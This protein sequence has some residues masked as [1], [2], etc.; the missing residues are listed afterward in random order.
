[1]RDHVTQPAAGLI[2]CVLLVFFVF[3]PAMPAH[4]QCGSPPDPRSNSA[5]YASWCGCMGGS[6]NYQ[7]TACTGARS[8]APSSSSSSSSSSGGGW[9][10]RAESR[11]GA[12]GYGKDYATEA[13]ARQIALSYCRQN[14]R[15]QAC[16]ITFC[17]Y[18]A[19]DSV[20]R[21]IRAA[22]AQQSRSPSYSV[23]PAWTGGGSWACRAEASNN[24]AGW[25][26][27]GATEADAKQGAL[28][29]C[30][31]YSKGRACSI[32]F[33][34]L[35][36]GDAVERPA[37]V[38][39]KLAPAAP[40]QQS[41]RSKAITAAY[42]CGECHRKLVADVDKAWASSSTRHYVRLALTDYAACKLKATGACFLGDI[43]ARSLENA[44]TSF[45]VEKDYRVCLGRTLG[46]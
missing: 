23:A 3:A 15:G 2:G 14:S 16:N 34:G 36:A 35:G 30:R 17:G 32:K 20:M 24:A 31:Q 19:G 38:A 9:G 33:C 29:N 12:Y 27:D 1:M 6:Y 25:V 43:F 11:S 13:E 4:A 39:K 26:K 44:C 10:C 37:P 8:S 22:P 42:D 40:V 45:K 46:R 21:P 18:G 7:T 41:A 28:A 5:G